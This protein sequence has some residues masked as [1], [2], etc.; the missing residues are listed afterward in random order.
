MTCLKQAFTFAESNNFDYFNT[1]FAPDYSDP[2][3]PSRDHLRAKCQVSLAMHDIDKISKRRIDF[4]E[5]NDSTAKI[6]AGLL[7]RLAPGQS[8]N[9]AGGT[10]IFFVEVRFYFE[11]QD[12]GEWM[13]RTCDPVSVNNQPLGWN[14]VP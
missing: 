13:I 3:H 10:T 14:S 9:Y 8:S 6:L 11:K 2:A 7:I 1:V 4:E 12:D 5:M